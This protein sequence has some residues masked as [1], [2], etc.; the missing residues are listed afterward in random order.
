M[1]TDQ[2]HSALMVSGLCV[3]SL[4]V[5]FGSFCMLFLRLHVSVSSEG[6]FGIGGRFDLHE[7]GS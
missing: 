4:L 2:L 6:P 3:W 1:R 7:E 5:P